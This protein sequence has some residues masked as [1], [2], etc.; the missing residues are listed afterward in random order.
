MQWFPPSRGRRDAGHA[1]TF[2]S[3]QLPLYFTISYEAFVLVINNTL[4]QHRFSENLKQRLF[5]IIYDLA[6]LRISDRYVKQGMR[7]GSLDILPNFI[8]TGS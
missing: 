1:L 2:I 5:A 4:Y 6:I 3:A 8:K 7:D